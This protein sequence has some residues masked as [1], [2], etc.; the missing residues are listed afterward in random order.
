[1]FGKHKTEVL[2]VG[3]GPVGLFAALELAE[4]GIEVEII[5]GQW[6]TAAHSYALALH[7]ASLELLDRLGLADDLLGRGHVVDTV[8]FYDGKERRGE[9]RLGELPGKFPFVLVLPQQALEDTLEKRLAE[10]KVKVRWNHRLSKLDGGGGQAT[11]RIDKLMKEASGYA[12]SATGWV[13]DKQVETRADFV[14]GADGLKSAVRRELDVEFPEL[15]PRQFFGVF[16]LN[17]AMGGANEVRVVLDEGTTNVLWP[18]RGDHFRWSFQLADD[19]E[20]VPRSRTKSRL[21]VQVGDEAYPYLDEDKLHELVAARAPWFDAEIGEVTWSVAVR[22]EKRL[23]SSFG[24]GRVWLAGDA[25]HVAGPVGVQ[26]MNVGFREA[27]D[28][29]EAIH[30]VL[31]GGAP[32]STLDAYAGERRHEWRTL[33]GLDGAVQAGDG[34]GDWMRARGERILP[35]VPASGEHLRRLLAQVDLTLES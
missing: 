28:L 17:A 26:S 23:A 15:G 20:F 1:M 10:E 32:E 3:A 2:V 6:R 11:A 4:R 7:P 34:A 30:A 5:D 24:S 35:C 14:V 18:M 13:V 31:R 29:V 19:W 25:A 27:H 33:L 8:A 21:T 12:Y 16:E 22:F 9:L